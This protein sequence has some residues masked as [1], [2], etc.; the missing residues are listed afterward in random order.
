MQLT[1]PLCY[2]NQQL[3]QSHKPADVH[4]IDCLII[5]ALD[6]TNGHAARCT[7]EAVQA[8]TGSMAC[9]IGLGLVLHLRGDLCGTIFP[10]SS[11]KYLCA[12]KIAFYTNMGIS[13][14]PWD[15]TL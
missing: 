12:G 6:F 2:M 11:K 14:P 4:N 8:Q 1:F 10:F 15:L 7:S 13:V 5:C 3:H 9:I